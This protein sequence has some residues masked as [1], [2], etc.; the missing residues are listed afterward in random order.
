VLSQSVLFIIPLLFGT[1]R[2]KCPTRVLSHTGCRTDT[3]HNFVASFWPA[4]APRPVGEGLGSKWYCFHEED[5]SFRVRRLYILGDTGEHFV[6]IKRF[7]D[8]ARYVFLCK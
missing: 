1:L 7:N 3:K 8:D 4:T 6:N 5:R 2:V